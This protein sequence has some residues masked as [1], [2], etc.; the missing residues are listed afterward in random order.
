MADRIN[1]RTLSGDAKPAA[2]FSPAIILAAA[3]SNGSD[4]TCS[5]VMSALSDASPITAISRRHAARHSR[6]GLNPAVEPQPGKK[7][8]ILT[9]FNIE[10]PETIELVPRD[11]GGK[12]WLGHPR[13]GLPDSQFSKAKA[14]DQL[15]GSS[16]AASPLSLQETSTGN[17]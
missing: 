8:R 16:A 6:D 9:L 15:L 3:N 10:E 13:R 14:V 5:I 2:S 4:A 12:L 1:S 11:E 7:T 17:Q